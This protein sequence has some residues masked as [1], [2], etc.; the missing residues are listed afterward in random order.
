MQVRFLSKLSLFLVFLTFPYFLPTSPKLLRCTFLDWSAQARDFG[1][2]GRNGTDGQSG[3]RGRDGQSQ[4]VF[5]NGSPVNLDLSG[6]DASDGYDGRDGEDA[7]CGRQPRDVDDNLRA[8]NGGRGGNGGNGGDGGNGGSLTIYYTNPADLKQISVRSPGGRGGRGSR[9]GY[10]GR[11]CDCRDRNWE[12]KTCKGTPGSPDYSCTTRRFSC[13][14]GAD[15]SHG[16]DGRDG[17][18]GSLGTLTLINRTEALPPDNPTATVAM[19]ELTN[20]VFRLSKNIFQTRNGA[21]SLLAPG[22]VIADQYNEFM[23]R[24]EGTVQVIWNASRPITDFTGE[25]VAV[26][27]EENKQ[28]K[29]SFP[30]DVWVEGTT[31]QQ[32]DTTQFIASNAILK[33]EVTQLK[34]ADFSGSGTD[35]IFAVID[36]AGKSDLISTQFR[37]KYKTSESGDAFRRNYDYRTRYEGNMPAELVTRNNN[38]FV[39]NI[40]KLPI[41]SQYLRSG[42]PV[43]IELVATRSFAGRSAEQKIEW[44]GEIRR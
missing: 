44:R 4:T 42:L 1:R 2:D 24:L 29:I 13:S 41:Q 19:S 5:A 43:E 10:G 14:D 20:R 27:F 7:D 34:R 36:A 23:E 26:S 33:K 39:L 40:G 12:V 18:D 28:V 17:R 11:G 25:R 9:G 21:A 6:E 31:S 35:L 16:S 15:G 37:I 30:E 22:S 3:R 8:A 32:G 38:R